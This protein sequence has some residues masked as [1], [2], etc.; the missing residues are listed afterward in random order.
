MEFSA[1]MI[2]SFLKGEVAGNKN[3]VVTNYAK[4]EEG[5]NG[6]LCFL[7][8][9]KYEHYI[10]T[11]DASIVVVSD[12]FSPQSEVKATLIKVEDP[13]KAFADLL[14]LYVANK[15]QPEGVSEKASISEKATIGEN[16][17]IGDFTVVEDG[18]KIGSNCKIYPQVYIGL[19]VKIGDNVTLRPGVKIYEGCVLGNNIE[20]H[21]G[22][23]IGS[24]GFGYAPVGDSYEKIPQIGNVIIEDDVDM[25]SN[26]TIDRSTMGSTIIHKGV[27]LDNLC[28]CAHNTEI[29]ENTVAA[30]FLGVAGSSKVGKNCV[31]AGQVG[32]VGHISVADRT[33][34]GSLAGITRTIKEENGSYLGFPSIDSNLFKRIHVIQKKLPDMY[35]EMRTMQKEIAKLKETI[36]KFETK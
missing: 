23:I 33:T 7:S 8:N 35:T 1:E 15:P 31:I 9:P 11:T 10:Y 6:D 30:A 22:T 19:G 28:H 25:G 20:L 27:K 16:N 17:Y 13:Y 14:V 12:K 32:I 3:S 5:K 18:A 4:I 21:A 29:G 36:E 34:I 24:D 2:A 26:C